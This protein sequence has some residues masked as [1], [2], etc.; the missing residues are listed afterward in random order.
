M[1]EYDFREQIREDIET[2]Q[3]E[4]PGMTNLKKE[5]W[6]FNYWVLDKLFGEDEDEIEN[7]IID[8]HDFGVDC[9]VW[10]EESQ[11]L[12]LIQNKF[13]NDNSRVDS[14]YIRNCLSDAFGQLSQGTFTRC[15]EV[16]RIF[17]NHYRKDNNMDFRIHHY[18]YVTN[19][20]IT[21]STRKVISQFNDTYSDRDAQIFDLN[22]IEEAYYGTPKVSKTNLDI[23]LATVNKG[24]R[25][26]IRSDDYGIDL[27]I[28][29]MYAMVPVYNLYEA[30]VK[31]KEA[32]YPIFDANIREYLGH[33]GRINK[34][35]VETLKSPLERNRFF[36]Y[37]NGITIICDEIKNE[38]IMSQK[39]SSNKGLRVFTIVNPQIVNGCQ[40]VSSIE[41]V[42]QDV[43]EDRLREE[44]EDVFVMAKILELPKDNDEM[45]SLRENIV[46]YNNSQN[47]ID[48]KTFE[49]INE[50]FVS[51]QKN[52]EE[53]GF[54]LLIK[55]SDAHMF[56]KKY[57]Q[58][59]K[60]I[61]KNHELLEKFGLQDSLTRTKHFE[62]K[63]DKFLQV[64]L[65]FYGDGQQAFQKKG[66]LLKKD[67]AQYN[68]VTNALKVS[69]SG[70]TVQLA[71]EMYLLYLRAEQE[72]KANKEDGKVPITWYMFESI[73]KFDC[74]DGTKVE[75]LSKLLEN[76][77]SI[78]DLIKTYTGVSKLYLQGYANNN[79]GKEYNA[80]IKE[81]LDLGKVKEHLE[82][83]KVLG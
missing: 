32:S 40:T 64:M 60:L 44:F 49:A 17:N 78:D 6:A 71:L 59:S 75:N 57:P 58:P 22:D 30:L 63:L 66:N 11:D 42:L 55:Q 31:A 72:K 33:T 2:Y 34:R 67:S 10:H 47:S 73:A 14:N 7:K 69:N 3:E 5:E 61:D 39:D 50:L 70:M 25:L 38:Q 1:A 56:E 62:I 74:E 15:D 76:K 9:Y 41:H 26:T 4:H 54:L 20:E 36:F 52:F 37:N 48:E 83:L 51:Y 13:Y 45:R 43:P 29:G 53:K 80:M 8:Y 46:R 12:Y 23:E 28:D 27:P 68:L 82:L 21:D 77:E 18:F 19:N 35:I 24:T 79:P 65:A 81:K 16:Q